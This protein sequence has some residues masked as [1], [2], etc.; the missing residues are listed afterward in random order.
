ML[1]VLLMLDS[2]SFLMTIHL[3][4]GDSTIVYASDDLDTISMTQD[5][6]TVS[7]TSHAQLQ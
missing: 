1:T 4:T 7:V 5:E 2:L 6:L 3:S